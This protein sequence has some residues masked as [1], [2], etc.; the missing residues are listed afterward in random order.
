MYS[1][2]HVD[3]GTLTS[4]LQVSAVF[5]QLIADLGRGLMPFSLTDGDHTDFLPIQVWLEHMLVEI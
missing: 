3:S 5:N 4:H 2:L 1:S